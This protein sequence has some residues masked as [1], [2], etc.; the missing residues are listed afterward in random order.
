[1]G[2]DRIVPW[3]A[4]VQ[5]LLT[6]LEVA[7]VTPLRSITAYNGWLILEYSEMVEGKPKS[8]FA[9]QH[10]PDG[11]VQA[12]YSLNEAKQAIDGSQ[13]TTKRVRS[14]RSNRKSE[15]SASVRSRL[16]QL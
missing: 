8:R 1:M 2:S 13:A 12:G 7:L 6:A 14:S 3:A 15:P 9:V 10:S 4:P 11:P 5:E 16:A